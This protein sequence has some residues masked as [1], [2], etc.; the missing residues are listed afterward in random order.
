MHVETRLGGITLDDDRL[1]AQ[2]QFAESFIGSHRGARVWG[3]GVVSRGK[4]RCV[5]ST[6][7]A[8]GEIKDE[9]RIGRV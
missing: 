6:Q 4:E 8:L 1:V 7:K 9:A 5:K 3:L 2:G